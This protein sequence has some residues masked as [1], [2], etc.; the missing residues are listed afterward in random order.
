MSSY[1]HAQGYIT[2]CKV[3]D[4]RLPQRLQNLII[5]DYITK[6]GSRQHLS[7]TEIAETLRMPVLRGVLQSS[8]LNQLVFV[9]VCQIAN[10]FQVLDLLKAKVD[11]G[12]EL[13]FIAE[14]LVIRNSFDLHDLALLLGVERQVTES[15]NL[16]EIAL[17]TFNE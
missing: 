13:H 9:S 12:L 15:G 8:D 7:A 16:I 11:D 10:F 3:N 4:F 5:R 14:G 2:S 17:R 1:R 6:I